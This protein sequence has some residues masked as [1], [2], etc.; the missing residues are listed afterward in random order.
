MEFQS[1]I[2]GAAKEMAIKVLKAP[3][4]NGPWNTCFSPGA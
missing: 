3:L 4:P 1:C 2:P